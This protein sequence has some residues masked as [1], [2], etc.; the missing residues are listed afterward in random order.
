MNITCLKITTFILYI[1]LCT[2][3]GVELNDLL[4]RLYTS[5]LLLCTNSNLCK[6][7]IRVL[8][9]RGALCY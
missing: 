5:F 2:T 8:L 9:I 6:I 4:P 7:R 3:H 1:I